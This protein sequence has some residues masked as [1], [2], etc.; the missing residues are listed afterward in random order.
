MARTFILPGRLMYLRPLKHKPHVKKKR[1]IYDAVWAKAEVNHPDWEFP[2][3]LAQLTGLPREYFL[4][5]ESST[6]LQV[7]KG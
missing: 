4:C 2:S 6:V 5:T 1:R 7:T 3:I